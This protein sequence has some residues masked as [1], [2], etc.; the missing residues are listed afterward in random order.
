MILGSVQYENYASDYEHFKRLK[1]HLKLTGAIFA[2]WHS[3]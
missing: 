3:Y 2:I 1:P